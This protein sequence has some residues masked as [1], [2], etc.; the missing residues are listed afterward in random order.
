MNTQGKPHYYYMVARGDKQVL[1]PD[2]Q[3]TLGD[4]P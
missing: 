3:F 1:F 2:N 4:T